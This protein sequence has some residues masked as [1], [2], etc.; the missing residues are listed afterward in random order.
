MAG[1]VPVDVPVAVDVV[2]DVGVGGGLEDASP[3]G[4]LLDVFFGVGSLRPPV[5]RVV[6]TVGSAVGRDSAERS[7]SGSFV[8]GSGVGVGAGVGAAEAAVGVGV[9]STGSVIM[10]GRITKKNAAVP[11]TIRASN[12]A[13]PISATQIAPDDLRGSAGDVVACIAGVIPSVS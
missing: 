12:A 8:E 3:D 1:D 4:G 9:G 13:P 6:A 11:A 10:R 7:E 5:P 2:V